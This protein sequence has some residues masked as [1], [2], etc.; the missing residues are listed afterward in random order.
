LRFLSEQLSAE[1]WRELRWN[2]A[3]VEGT[4]DG[5]DVASLEATP[6]DVAGLRLLSD[7]RVTGLLRDLGTGDGLAKSA[8][9]AVA[10]ASAVGLLTIPGTGLSSYVAGGR[11]LQSVWLAAT[12]EGL[13]FQPMTALLYLFARLTRGGGGLP[14]PEL[15]ELEALR[16]KFNALFTTRSDHAELMLF[17]I[18]MAGAPSA[19]SLRRPIDDIFTMM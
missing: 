7:S 5:I 4:R 17:R 3:E 15:L 13:A 14:E 10:A 2:R 8:K 12:A 19:R 18:S 9:R 16:E 1:L 6:A 11:A